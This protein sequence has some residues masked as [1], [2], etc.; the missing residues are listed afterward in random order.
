MKVLK[1]A[2]G[3]HSMRAWKP[4]VGRVA[5]GMAGARGKCASAGGISRRVWAFRCPAVCAWKW[6]AVG[7][8]MGSRWGVDGGMVGC[9]WESKQPRQ[10][11]G[12]QLGDS[13]QPLSSATRAGELQP[14]NPA[15]ALETSNTSALPN[16]PSLHSSAS[17]L[18]TPSRTTIR[19][20][21]QTRT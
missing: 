13:A 5:C 19:T 3:P 18:R 1:E 9:K 15:L 12:W 7:E 10:K 4:G 20:N 14:P 16:S 8:Q 2:P 17:P 21:T 11:F 6:G